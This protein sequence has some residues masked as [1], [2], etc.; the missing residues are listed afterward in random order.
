MTA[1]TT[2]SSPS[3]RPRIHSRGFRLFVAR[4][5]LTALLLMGSA[6][7]A[8]ATDDQIVLLDK[9]VTSAKADDM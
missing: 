3:Q 9:F 8:S 6:V 5:L 7:G 2:V 4:P 1:L